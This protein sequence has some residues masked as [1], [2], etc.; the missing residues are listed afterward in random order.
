MLKRFLAVLA[1]ATLAIGLALGAAMPASAHTPQATATCSTLTVKM[2]AYGSGTTNKLKV[3]IDGDVVENTTFGNSFAAKV[4]TFSGTVAHT[5]VVEVDAQD[6]GWDR[7]GKDALTGTTKPCTTAQCTNPLTG[8]NNFT[9]VT[10]TTLTVSNGGAHVEGTAAV[11]T[12]L[13]VNNAYHVQN[14]HDNTGL[15]VVDGKTTGLLVGGKVT[16]ATTGE[17]FQVNAGATRVGDTAGAAVVD[18]SRFRPVA[19]QDSFIRMS[20]DATLSDVTGSGLFASTFPNLFTNL[21]AS[22]DAIANYNSGDVNFVTTTANGGDGQKVTLSAGVVNVL[23]VTPT[24]LSAITKLWFDG[25]VSP[26]SSTPFIIDVTGNS[27]VTASAPVLMNIDAHYVLWNFKATTLN[28]STS[29][30][31]KGSIL[32]PRAQLNLTSGGIEGQIAA[33]SMVV[34]SVGEIHHI[35][36]TSCVTPPTSVSGAATSTAEICDST[37][38]AV[39]PGSVTAT[40]KTGVVYQLW[41]AAKDAKIADLVAGTAYAI[42]DGTYSVKVLPASTSYTVSDANTWITVTVGAYTGDCTAPQ[43]VT[44]AAVAS[45]EYC[46]VADYTVKQGSITATAKT[47]VKYELWNAAQTTKIADLTGGTAYRTDDGTYSVKV[48]AASA[49]YVVAPGNTWITVVVGAYTDPCAES[50][51]G[52]AIATAET[53]DTTSYDITQG[54]VIATAKTGVKYEL[55]NAAQTTK[56]ADL[57]AG[58][59]YKVGGGT[60]YVKVL[61]ASAS[62]QVASANTW[63]Q[64]VVGAYT[65]ICAQDVSG[66]ASASAEFCDSNVYEVKPGSITANAATGVTYELWNAAKTTKIADLTAGTAYATGNG[67]YQV[68]VLPASSKY[69]VAADNTWIQVVV[70]TYTGTC[71]EGVSGSA[72]STGE[73]CDPADYEIAKGSV[74]ANV[75]TGVIYELWNSAKTSKIANL[76]AGTAYQVDSGTYFVKVLPASNKY[77]VDPSNTWIQVVVGTFTGICA[78]DVSG[79][80]SGSPETCDTTDYEI[81]K[82]SVLATAVTGVTYE[83]WNA[84]KTTK[85]ADLTGGTAYAVDGGTYF[86]KVLTTTDK[87]DV[88]SANTW[89]EVVVVDYTG[90]CAQDVS[91][92][93]MSAAE[94][95]DAS[96]AKKPVVAKGAVTATAAAGVTYELWDVTKTTKIAN[97]TAGTAYGVGGGTYFVKVLP[98]T[99]KYTVSGP[100]T[101]IEVVVATNTVVCEVIGDPTQF[102]QCVPDL[103][104][105]TKSTW[106]ASLTI[107]AAQHVEYRVYLSNGTTWVDQGIWA[108]G[109]YDAGTAKLPYGSVVQVVAQPESGWSL[110]APK[111]WEFTFQK[112]VD[113]NLPTFGTVTPEVVFAQTCEAGASYKLAIAG[114]VPG[115]VLWSVNGGPQTTQLG[116]FST[117]A[118]GTVKIVATPA[119]GYGFDGNGLPRTFEKTFTDAALC[120]LETLAFTGQNVTGYL[121]IAVI[122]F[123]A[124]LALVAVQFVRA[125]RRA[126]HL[127]V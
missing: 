92:A 69:D 49:S 8:L 26:S 46:D 4:Y 105:L 85:I 74:T 82:G 61:A 75:A 106:T 33:K 60:Y 44:G 15:P 121:V 113:C 18:G 77:D 28:L 17:A 3:T 48:L 79:A 100:N 120:D 30:F 54:S 67:T 83:L 102:E 70:G 6:A 11:G 109:R 90:L 24:Q 31:V 112:A 41:N 94:S 99:D 111:S 63:I 35:G 114:G 118:P 88:S 95:C 103:T 5:W 93:A 127:A 89:I 50:V 86:V 40:A 16:L 42:G 20:A 23:R 38:Y 32:A 78:E 21:R 29:E 13:I 47:G 7:L 71:A 58:T 55:W 122:L 101:W 97:L 76:T 65:G 124:G 57:T 56:I 84:A 27:T 107:V 119:T 2:D 125:R 22:S 36:Y 34:T 25:G 108:A 59:P 81:A 45:A 123:Q 9:I 115:S 80:A 39:L 19:A 51:T 62:Y 116:T 126:R 64:V 87:Y 96:D 68:K 66:S 12:D 73:V 98:A 91:G 10:E 14:N 43:N 117:S 104:D 37:V 1:T 72:G 53:C 52:A 110:L